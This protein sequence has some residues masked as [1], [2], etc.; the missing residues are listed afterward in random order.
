MLTASQ[1]WNP[2]E[3]VLVWT[4]TDRCSHFLASESRFQ[5]P[6]ACSEGKTSV[7]LHWGGRPGPSTAWAVPRLVTQRGEF[8]SSQ[9]AQHWPLSLEP[10]GHHLQE[11]RRWQEARLGPTS[12][13]LAPLS[14]GRNNQYVLRPSKEVSLQI[15][16]SGMQKTKLHLAVV[17][18]RKAHITSP[19][20]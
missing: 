5:R 19:V 18:P 9:D 13:E 1:K 14:L 7:G 2:S 12:L 15:W 17:N 3:V 6:S 16:N 4:A 10:C 20:A 11:D 8:N